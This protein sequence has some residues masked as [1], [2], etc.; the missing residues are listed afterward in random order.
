MK[1]ITATFNTVSTFAI[2]A[3]LVTIGAGIVARRLWKQHNMTDRSLAL[4]VGFIMG[5]QVVARF[6]TDDVLPTLQ[7][8]WSNAPTYAA[9]VYVT[10]KATVKSINHAAQCTAGLVEAITLA[11]ADSAA[12]AL[13]KRAVK[14]SPQLA[15]KAL[16]LAFCLN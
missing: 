16:E 12:V 11:V 7:A 15:D 4:L 2:N 9:I 3:A 1:N 8:H 14:A 5:C 13:F 6:V 10:A